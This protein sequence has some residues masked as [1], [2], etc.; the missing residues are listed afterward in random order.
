MEKIY[1]IRSEFHHLNQ[2]R[3]DLAIYRPVEPSERSE[4]AVLALHNSNYMS[5]PPAVELA[6]RGFL[7]AG[8]F[9]PPQHKDVQDW[10]GDF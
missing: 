5:F 1:E 4:I 8:A 9:L 6:K 2:R 3:I 10:L 7:T